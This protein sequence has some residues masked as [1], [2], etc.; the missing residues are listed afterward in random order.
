MPPLTDTALMSWVTIATKC[1]ECMSE[2]GQ[3][4]G[5]RGNQDVMNH[6][7]DGN[8]LLVAASWRKYSTGI[9]RA[10]LPVNLIFIQRWSGFFQLLKVPNPG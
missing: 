1:G 5:V 4:F 8:D 3:M 6:S 2:G 9:L 10:F 7:F